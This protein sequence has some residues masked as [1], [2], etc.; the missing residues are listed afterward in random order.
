M[1]RS[2]H[3]VTSAELWSKGLKKTDDDCGFN[4]TKGTEGGCYAIYGNM[5][6]FSGAFAIVI[7]IKMSYPFKTFR[8]KNIFLFYF[9][10]PLKTAP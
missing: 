5:F 1:F 3:T 4:T 7:T 2:M 9:Q 6:P 8:K 10:V